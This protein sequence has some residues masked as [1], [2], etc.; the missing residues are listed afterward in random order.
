MV[1][2][3]WTRSEIELIRELINDCV[4]AADAEIIADLRRSSGDKAHCR[5]A[6]LG[7]LDVLEKVRERINVRFDRITGNT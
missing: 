5:G 3:Q 4:S 6:L 7:E 2:S 1:T